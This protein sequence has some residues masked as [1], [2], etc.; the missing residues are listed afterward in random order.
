M[1]NGNNL[2]HSFQPTDYV[3]GNKKGLTKRE[4][5][6]GL[7]LQTMIPISINKYQQS[8]DTENVAYSAHIAVMAA[9]LLLKALEENKKP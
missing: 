4:Y 7:A 6:A 9:D 3:E 2:M 8:S 5:F 1:E